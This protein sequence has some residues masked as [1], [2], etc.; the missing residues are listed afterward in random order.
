MRRILTLS[1]LA[2][3]LAAPAALAQAQVQPWRPGLPPYD[4]YPGGAPA[5]IANQHRFENDRLR[6]QA[7]SNSALARQL[8]TETRLR[9]QTIEAAREPALVPTQPPRPLYAP[10][11]ERSLREG[12]A[13]RRQRTEQGMSQID[14][15]LDRR[16]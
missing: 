14:N 7:Q 2:A 10:E 16:D 6:N 8:Q 12:A 4:G 11:T 9:Q 1:A 15:W 5:A 13:A 3:V